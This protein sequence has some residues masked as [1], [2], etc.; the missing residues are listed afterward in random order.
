MKY[1]N[2]AWYRNKIIS[3][4]FLM[5]YEACMLYY[6]HDENYYNVSLVH[7][8]SIAVVFVSFVFLLFIIFPQEWLTTIMSHSV[9]HGNL[10][11]G[12]TWW[13]IYKVYK[14][15]IHSLFVAI[16]KLTWVASQIVRLEFQLILW[17][18]WYSTATLGFL[19]TN[20]E[21]LWWLSVF[22]V[23]ILFCVY[24]ACVQ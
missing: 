17:Q 1:I 22:Y 13:Y 19:V 3:R 16:D 24:C 7:L 2:K 4:T 14:T 12:G 8:C 21:L 9:C 5:K 18:K 20:S 23:K 6:L 11:L 15:F 10:H